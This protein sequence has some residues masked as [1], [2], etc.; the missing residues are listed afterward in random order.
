MALSQDVRNFIKDLR[1]SSLDGLHI[2]DRSGLELL[3]AVVN[4]MES[5]DSAYDID[6]SSG[7]PAGGARSS[8]VNLK[9]N[10]ADGVKNLF[11]QTSKVTVTITGGTATG[12]TIDGAAGPT[13]YTMQDGE[14]EI[15]VAA[16]STG[17][18]VLGLSAPDPSGLTVTD[19]HT[20]TFS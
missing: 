10:D 18:V 4:W 16:T 2:S 8:L 13:E 1:D 5:R 6:Y 9:L 11:N 20:V 14:K 7:A 15:A 19:T 17:T 3:G 12:P